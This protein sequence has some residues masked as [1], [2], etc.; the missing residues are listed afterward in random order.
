MTLHRLSIGIVLVATFGLSAVLLYGV[1]H[2]RSL[3]WEPLL[4]AIGMVSD[5]EAKVMREFSRFRNFAQHVI[6]SW[7]EGTI[8][9]LPT[10]LAGYFTVDFPDRRHV[11]GY[12]PRWC[13]QYLDRGTD[14]WGS[15]FEFGSELVRG[16]GRSAVLYLT[17]QC[18]G[19]NRIDE[20]GEG[21]DFQKK[22][23]FPCLIPTKPWTPE[24]PTTVQ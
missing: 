18:V 8:E 1:I 7:E 15:K 6:W 4:H 2:V 19:A 9:D 13:L 14:P 22:M 12:G 10:T 20:N 3:Q 16:E 21:D 11:F 17:V 24:S 5:D 23:N